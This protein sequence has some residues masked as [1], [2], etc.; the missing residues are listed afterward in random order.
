MS[1]YKGG[2]SR[3]LDFILGAFWSFIL[4]GIIVAALNIHWSFMIL[5]LLLNIATIVYFFRQ[6]RSYISI[7][8]LAVILLPLLLFGAC[9]MVLSQINL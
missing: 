9:F 7:G 3:G 6:G 2:F 1:E 8:I 5:I 4:N